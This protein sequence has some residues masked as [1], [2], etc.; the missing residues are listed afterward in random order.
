M[1]FVIPPLKCSPGGQWQAPLLNVEPS[2]QVCGH[3]GFVGSFVQSTF[4]HEG[5]FGVNVQSTF[6]F[7][8]THM[9][10]LSS[11]LSLHVGTIG[12]LTLTGGSVIF[13]TQIPFFNISPFLHVGGG[14][15]LT[16]GLPCVSNVSP[17]PP[18][19]PLFPFV[20]PDGV[21]NGDFWQKPECYYYY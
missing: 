2:G 3:L 11:S 19:I 17:G 13:G 5:S 12:G 16:G 8:G 20:P 6:V 14:G 10:S 9:P 18:G 21:V 1:H 7:F 15:G 4:G